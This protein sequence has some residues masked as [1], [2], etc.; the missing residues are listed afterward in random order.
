MTGTVD[1]WI[2]VF[3]FVLLETLVLC[4]TCSP[5]LKRR[6]LI[7]DLIVVAEIGTGSGVSGMKDQVAC[8]ASAWPFCHLR[9]HDAAQALCG[10]KAR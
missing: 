7:D 4:H 1:R 6:R 10:G 5:G 2:P 9:L 8:A 3:S